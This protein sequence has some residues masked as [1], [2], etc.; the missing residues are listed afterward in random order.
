MAVPSSYNASTLAHAARW[1]YDP[2]RE[3]KRFVDPTNVNTKGKTR[4][5]LLSSSHSELQ[6]ECEAFCRASPYP[7][8]RTMW[9]YVWF[10]ALINYYWVRDLLPNLV[11]LPTFPSAVILSQPLRT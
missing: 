2:G 5:V 10:D 1:E 7:S 8:I 3:D 11:Y 4:G 9:F 6:I